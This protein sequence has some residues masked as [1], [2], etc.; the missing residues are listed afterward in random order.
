MDVQLY[1]EDNPNWWDDDELIGA[2]SQCSSE[3]YE[4][5]NYQY[6]DGE[7]WCTDCQ[8]DIATELTFYGFN[9]SQRRR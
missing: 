9:Y 6:L 3:V 2:C 7:L 5:Q 4:E 8:D 1:E